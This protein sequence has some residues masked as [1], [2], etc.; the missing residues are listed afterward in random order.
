[1]TQ[2]QSVHKQYR[3]TGLILP[4]TVFYPFPT[5]ELTNMIHTKIAVK[6]KPKHFGLGF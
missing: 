1:M 5:P 6:K 2:N 4:T 3:E